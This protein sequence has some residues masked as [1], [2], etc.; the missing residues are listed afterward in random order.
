[1]AW[2]ATLI[3]F[4]LW[5]TASTSNENGADAES[6]IA[7]NSAVECDP[8]IDAKLNQHAG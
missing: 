8:A 5:M 2:Y 7:F 1:M 6:G 4:H 3:R